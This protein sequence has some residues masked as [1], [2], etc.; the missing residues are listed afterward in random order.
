MMKLSS[1]SE[2]QKMGNYTSKNW[3]EMT[4]MTEAQHEKEEEMVSYPYS[5]I[6]K[7]A[8]ALLY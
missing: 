3:E 1:I 6:G 5:L 2:E 8:F 7:M 4:E